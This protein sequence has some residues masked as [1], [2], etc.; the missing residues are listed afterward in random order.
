MNRVEK[1]E[2]Q[3]AFVGMEN[4]STTDWSNSSLTRLYFQA[5]RSFQQLLATTK[6]PAG[7]CKRISILPFKYKC[8][9]GYDFKSPSIG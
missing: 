3:A 4:G 7:S 5:K 8:P 1:P 2:T 9:L 6:D